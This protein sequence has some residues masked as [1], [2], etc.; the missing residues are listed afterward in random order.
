MPKREK[1]LRRIITDFELRTVLHPGISEDE[2]AIAIE[3]L[4]EED[5]LGRWG[6]RIIREKLGLKGILV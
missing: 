6:A 5:K 4:L 2:M 3:E 1:T